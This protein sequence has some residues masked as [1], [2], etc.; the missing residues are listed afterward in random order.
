MVNVKWLAEGKW[1][2][3]Y[4]TDLFNDLSKYESDRQVVIIP[5]A[6]YAERAEEVNDILREYPKVLAVITSDEESL[7][8]ADDITHPDCVIY[9]QYP[10]DDKSKSV[11]FW[12]PIMYTPHIRKALK[13][14]GLT[15]KSL[16]W[17]FSGQITHERREKLYEKLKD[18]PGGKLLGTAGFTQGFE[19]EEY[20]NYMQDAKVVPSPWGVAKPE[21]FRTYEALEAGAVP[22]PQGRDYHRKIL[23]DG[24]FTYLE[25]WD[26][27]DAQIADYVQRYP[28]LNNHVM[29]WWLQQKRRIKRRFMQD[30]G[31]QHSDVTV[32]MSTS[33]IPTNPSTEV[34]EKAIE[35]IRY[36]LPDA[37]ILIMADGVRKEQQH[38]QKDYQEFLRTILWKANL[39]WENITVIAFEEHEH[40]LGMTRKTLPLVD[41]ELVFFLEHDMLLKK[42]KIE[43]D[44]IIPLV[45]S[46]YM[47]TIRFYFDK[48]LEPA[49][50]YLFTS[51]QPE[52]INGVRLV[53]TGQWSQ[54]PHISKKSYYEQILSEYA[55][56][57]AYSMIEDAIHGLIA[58]DFVVNGWGHNKVAIYTPG[59]N[60]SFAY[61]IDGRGN[62][63]K[64]VETQVY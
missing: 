58:D 12:I 20:S 27:V 46:E 41:T 52:T 28:R 56:E 5:G 15:E 32:L 31:I 60:Y 18:M 53:K 48:Q 19:P 9:S 2:Q 25:E 39:E 50:E 42:R 17:F 38:L 22:I 4:L 7:F 63:S 29:S 37:E 23:D 54:R 33:P 35:S 11:D 64:F 24:I 8:D 10:T 6:E 57:N 43:W 36:H 34:I 55:S 61:H 30:L 16:D 49:H 51:M 13:K 14:R 47:D 44:K 3:T 59:D 40:Q 45:K 26:N 62:E 1:D 21:A